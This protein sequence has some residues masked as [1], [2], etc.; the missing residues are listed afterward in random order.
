MG[1]Q[2]GATKDYPR[3]VTFDQLERSFKEDILPA[4]EKRIAQRNHL[5]SDGAGAFKEA[6]KQGYTV[7][8]IP[9]ATEPD[10]AKKHLKWIHHFKLRHTSSWGWLPTYHGC[11]PKYRK[12]YLASE[13]AYR[14]NP[15]LLATTKPSTACS[16]PASG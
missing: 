6:E 14:F 3:F 1:V 12:A 13:F 16:P 8:P 4:L 10:K 11:S 9:F 2:E 7:H 15:A 5:K